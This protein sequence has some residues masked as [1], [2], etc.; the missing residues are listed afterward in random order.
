M[1]QSQVQ[2]KQ[3]LCFVLQNDSASFLEINSRNKVVKKIFITVGTIQS[4]STSE[5]KKKIIIMPDLY[6]GFNS[7][8]KH[9]LLVPNLMCGH[10][11]WL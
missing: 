1:L 6:L 5:T 10:I 8:T 9:F 4:H 3:K 11:L 2:L 7:I